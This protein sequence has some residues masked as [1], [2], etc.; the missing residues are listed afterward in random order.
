MTN[1][2]IDLR[3]MGVLEMNSDEANAINGGIAPWVGIAIA[4][5]GFVC[6]VAVGALVIY[7]LYRIM[8]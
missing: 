8:K 3:D 2:L 6:G 1:D 4:C 5:G 7:A